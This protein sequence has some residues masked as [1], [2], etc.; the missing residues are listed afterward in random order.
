MKVTAVRC[1]Q[2]SGP[3]QIEG[4]EERQL[5]MLDVYPE[6]AR[7]GP[8]GGSDRMTSVYVEV[9]SD[10]G[11]T[12]LFGPI[13]DETAPVLLRKVAPHVVGQDPLAYERIWDVMYRQDRHARKGYEMMA[14]SALDCALWDL[15]G[16]LLGQPVY[17]LLGGPTRERVECYASMLGYSHDPGLVRERAQMVVGQGFRAQKWFFRHGPSD[18]LE[19][20]EKNVALIR[21][22][23]EAVGPTVEIM[24]DC[25]MG[26]D[27]TYV[28]RLLERI[29]EFRP[30]WLEEP[31]PPDRIDD[32]VA[33]KRSTNVPIATG[34][35]EYTRWGFLQ[36]LKAGAVDVIQSDPDWCGGVSELVKICT[37]ASAFGKH[38]VPHGHS[39]HAALHVIAAQSPAVCPLAEFLLRAQQSKQHFFAEPMWPDGGSIAL[40]TAPGLGFGIKAEAI[41]RREEVGA[42]TAGR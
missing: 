20:M 1:L 38:V 12:G 36:L 17:R 32:F 40:P 21:T 24:V 11:A 25:F 41:D 9:E 33:I 14:I 22:V 5:Q 2:V 42:V 29:A 3:A 18:G 13:F 4:S 8:G 16:K 35:H 6:L 37:L 34:E 19:G 31:I 15:R 7:R 26:G 27:A 28:I 23:R 10:D 30:R 39:I